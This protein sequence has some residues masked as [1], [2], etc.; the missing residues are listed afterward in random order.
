MIESETCQAI[1]QTNEPP[2]ALY[3]ANFKS[4]KTEGNCLIIDI[5][6]AYPK[7]KAEDFEL[8]WN[9]KMKKSMPPQVTLALHKNSGDE[10]FEMKNFR[11]KYDLSSLKMGRTMITLKDYAERIDYTPIT[12]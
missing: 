12:D 9:G 3:G 5:E 2:S 8:R 11:L 4:V 6:M 10:G 1:T 7:A